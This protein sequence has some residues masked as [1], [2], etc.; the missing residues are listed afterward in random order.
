MTADPTAIPAAPDP[1]D[2]AVDAL[3]RRIAG[4]EARESEH[5]RSARIQRALYRI[6]EAASDSD[7]TAACY[8][9]VHGIV[10]ELMYAANFYIALY[11]AERRL[12]NYPYAVD[13]IDQTFPDPAV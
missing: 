5:Q 3:R 1:A 11:D 8:A 2:L 13:S 6:G 7:G 12:L 4:L 10:G 9:T